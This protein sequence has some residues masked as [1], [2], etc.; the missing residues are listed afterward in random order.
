MACQGTH[1]NWGTRFLT[2]AK[3]LSGNSFDEDHA[4]IVWHE[5]RATMSPREAYLHLVTRW[6]NDAHHAVVKLDEGE[7]M[8]F[9]THHIEEECK[10]VQ[11]LPRWCIAPELESD[12]TRNVEPHHEDVGSAGATLWL[13]GIPGDLANEKRVG[14][15]LHTCRPSTMPTPI[16]K[17]VVKKGYMHASE[18]GL[19]PP[20]WQGYAFVT[21]RDKAEAEEG[22]RL[23]GGLVAPGGW[24]IRVEWADEKH[25]GRLNR[26]RKL[27][28]RLAEGMDPPLGEQ[29]FPSS[30]HGQTLA[31]AIERH[32]T[33]VR[34]PLDPFH[35]P[36]VSAEIIKAHYRSFP[37]KEIFV[38]GHKLPDSMREPLLAELRQT[39]WPAA[40][41]RSGMQAEQYLV[42]HV[43]KAN[44]GFEILLTL[45]MGMLAWADPTFGCNRIAVTKDFQGSPHIDSSDVTYQYAV[46]LG[47]FD[48][49][50]Q[51][52][53]EGLRPSEVYVVDTHDCIARVDGRF[54]HW[55]RGHGGGDR[56][57]LIFFSTT[58]SCATEPVSPFDASFIPNGDGKR[59]DEGRCFNN[60]ASQVETH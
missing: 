20:S 54:V 14:E 6:F 44:D 19:S 2:V 30:L 56:Y 37:R 57:S 42:L 27:G 10:D 3:A 60:P 13:G 40:P 15:I 49:G 7:S 39:R 41:H 48:V 52:C 35:E 24:T 45:L 50:G 26:G 17:K 16:V 38:K 1:L 4:K 53:V 21:F 18:D 55:V 43:G 36:W 33:V 22:H 58:P 9:G 31:Q 51:L 23:L 59:H 32:R 12:S 46:S 47:S 8:R 5:V 28:A 11:W 25:Q 29:I 34:L